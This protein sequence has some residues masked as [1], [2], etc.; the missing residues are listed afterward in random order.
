VLDQYIDIKNGAERT[1]SVLIYQDFEKKASR[2]GIGRG[3][4]Y[5]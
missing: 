1:N 2:N 5:E 3:I 4:T